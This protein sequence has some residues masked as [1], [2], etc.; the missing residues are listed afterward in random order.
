LEILEQLSNWRLPKKDSAPWSYLVNA[1]KHVP[2]D[3]VQ[4]TE[5]NVIN[6][7]R[8][9]NIKFPKYF[10]ATIPYSFDVSR[11][12]YMHCNFLPCTTVTI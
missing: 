3:K 6:L 8:F 2:D 12:R 11:C 5:E 4:N 7:H 9:V 1:G 10:V